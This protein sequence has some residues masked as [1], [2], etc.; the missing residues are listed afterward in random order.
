MS[1]LTQKRIVILVSLLFLGALV[2]SLESSRSAYEERDTENNFQSPYRLARSVSMIDQSAKPQPEKPPY[3]NPELSWEVRVADLLSRMTLEEKVSQMVHDA[4][5]IERLGIPKYNWW[6]ECLHGVARAGLATVFPQ[7]IGLAAT[8]D[9]NLL[10]QV[11]TAI[12]DEA[13]AK[14]HYFVRQGKRNIYQGLTFWSPNINIFRDP[15]WGRGMETYGE[16]PYLAGR[17]GVAFVRGLQGNHPRYLKTV[18]TPKHYAVHSGPEPDR[19]TFNAQVDEGDLR[20]TYL[21]HFEACVKE[22]GA[23]SIMCAYNRFRDKACCGSPFLLGRILRLEWGFEGYVVSDCGAIYDIYNNH[24]IVPTAPEAAALAVKA[25]CD[26]NCGQTYRT[27]VKAV[28][29]GLLSEEDIDR[30]VRRLFLARFRLGM[31][32]PPEMVPYMAIPYSVVDCAEH[33]ELAREAARKSI[34]LLKNEGNIL[35][36]SRRIRTLAVIGP[37][38]N[39]VEVLLGNYNGTPADPITPLAGLKQKVSPQTKVIYAL[40]CDWAEGLPYLETIP[41]EYFF[42]HWQGKRVQ[43]LVGEYFDNRRL[44]GQ[45]LFTRLDPGLEFNWWDGAPDERLDDDNFGVRWTGELVPPR[46]GEYYLG[47]EGFN[48]F[49]IYLDGELIA[50]FNSSHHPRQIHRKIFLEGQR[51]YRLKVEFFE[52][53]GDAHLR[54]LW[55]VPGRDLLAEALEAARQAEAVVLFMGLSPRLEGEE[56]K[57][58]VAGFKGGDRLTLEL[59]LR[60]QELIKAVAALKKPT[61]LVLL[62]G[63]ALAVNWSAAHLP[64]IL[65][66]WYPG[67][68]AGEAIAD[69]LFGDYNP[70]GRLPVTFYKSVDQL[71]PFT[72]YRMENRTYRYFRGEPLFPFGYGLSYTRFHYSDL[73]VPKKVRAGEK[74]KVSVVVSN[75]GQRAGEEVVQLYLRD[76]EASVPVPIRSLKGFKRI[77]LQPGKKKR[78]FFELKP[79][80]LSVLDENWYRVVEPGWFEVSLG[81]KQPGFKGLAKGT[82]TEVLTTKFEVIKEDEGKQLK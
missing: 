30:A 77:H 74:V 22:G 48:G 34:V 3:L 18:A 52:R 82:T 55:K 72:D 15:R 67:Q 38:A 42:C 64:A 29:K 24:K 56:M 6:N 32:D 73:Q 62:N 11:A 13:R 1:K 69:V 35:P 66:A 80:D 79:E 68:A 20:E 53:S 45:P 31:F 17:L 14:H 21:P 4:P 49:R 28:E 63:S 39:D 70:A 50:E 16:D 7:A 37:N 76:L 36:L 65:E 19:H 78:V 27:L 71:P 44:T 57:V 61:I 5:A 41:P 54:L 75:I 81:G 47:G 60:Q 51:P 46:S 10:Y 25:G 9:T 23:F 8:W 26:L 43:G 12:S 58:E 59:P 2:F 33:R 40:G